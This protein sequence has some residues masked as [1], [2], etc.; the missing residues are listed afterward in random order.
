LSV[1]GFDRLLALR[2]GV[3]GLLEPMRAAGTLGASL[4][5]EAMLYLD[6]PLFTE[7]SPVAEELRF[8]FITSSLELAPS[9]KKQEM[10]AP[11]AGGIGWAAATPSAHAKCI[12]CW[13]YRADVGANAEH[14]EICLRCV[15]NVDGPGEDRKYF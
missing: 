15:S 4:Q 11:L 5:A 13:H 9:D 7:L 1:E 3:S 12:R 2:A 8:L 14:P 10:V 6:A